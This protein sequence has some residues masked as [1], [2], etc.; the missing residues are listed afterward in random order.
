MSSPMTKFPLTCCMQGWG[1][2]KWQLPYALSV[3]D[4]TDTLSD[5]HPVSTLPQ[6]SRFLV[7]ECMDDQ[8]RHSQFVDVWSLGVNDPQNKTAW[9]SGIRSN[10]LP[11]AYPNLWHT[12]SRWKIKSGSS[13]IIKSSNVCSPY[14][15]FEI[16]TKCR[17]IT[18]QMWRQ[19]SGKTRLMVGQK[20]QALFRHRAFC[21]ASDQRLMF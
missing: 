9:R 1:Y 17:P 2:R 18:L 20:D 4:G 6:I 12:R 7:Q 5:P 21:A 10:Q 15:K 8:E 16:F 13:K 11:A 19:S 14:H 3:L